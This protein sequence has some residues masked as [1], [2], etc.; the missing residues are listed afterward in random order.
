VFDSSTL[1]TVDIRYKCILQYL[2][3]PCAIKNYYHGLKKY[4]IE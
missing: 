1:D 4:S 3:S 2:C